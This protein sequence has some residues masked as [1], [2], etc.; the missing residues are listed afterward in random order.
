MTSGFRAGWARFRSN[1]WL[2]L[3]FDAALIVAIFMGVHSWQT[4]HLPIDQ[5]APHTVLSPL[6]G[7]GNQA[8]VN[9]G[10]VGI[11]YF[12]APWCGYCRVSIGNLQKLVDDGHVSWGTVVALD[13][14]DALEVQ[15]FIDKTGVTLPV[16]MGNAQTASDWGIKGF[17]TYYVIDA[18]GNISSRSVGYST[19]LGMWF[20]SWWAL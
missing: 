6:A 12:F 14:G 10:Q 18:Q 4:R 17:P 16:L 15:A 5:L 8:A 20:R 7:S 19:Q 13:Y 1:F 2:S 11:V 3:V 9:S